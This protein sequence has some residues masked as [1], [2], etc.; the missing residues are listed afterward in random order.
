MNNLRKYLIGLLALAAA[1]NP[2]QVDELIDPNNPNVNSVASNASRR[3]IQFLVTGLESRHRGYVTNISQAWNTFGREV[4]YLNGSDPRFQTD[5]LGQAGRVP[6]A[7]YFGFG[8]TGGGSYAVPYQAI[9]QAYVLMDAAQNTTFITEQEKKAVSGFAKTIMAYQFM[10]PANWLYQNGIRIDVKDPYNPGPFV[11]YNNALTFINQLL[12]EGYNDLVAAGTAQPFV[13]STEWSGINASVGT[14][15]SIDGLKKVNR[16]IAARLAVYREDWQGALDALDLSFMDLEGNLQT[17]PAH[18]YGGPPNI[19]NP[20]YYIPNA[21]VNTIIV[22]HPSM[23]DDATPGDLRVQNKFFE[24]TTPVTITT[25]AAPLV[26]THQDKRWASN[27]APIAFIR[28]EELILIKA[29]AHAQLDQ[30]TLAVDAI[31]VIREAADIGVY[32][33]GTTKAELIDE[34]LYQRRYSL[35]AEP[36]GHRWID[37]RRY[38]KLNEIP[39][40]YDLGTI[41]TQFP[42]PQAELNWDDYVGN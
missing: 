26:G 15:N 2:F 13:L 18:S 33:G 38:N 28:N 12:T 22:V 23:I 31:D 8:A 9:K 40:S 1:C 36:W 34:I 27:I 35:W 10:I 4:W 37:A 14:F 21:N 6:D 41:F 11:S 19:F 20:L 24:R 30:T 29:E 25:D 39:T 7:A 32:T 3:Q 17:G 42:V 5:W 16:A